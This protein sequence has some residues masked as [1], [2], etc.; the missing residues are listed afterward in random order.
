MNDLEKLELINT[1]EFIGDDADGECCNSVYVENNET[2][3]EII[4]KIGFD[5]DYIDIEMI[6]EDECLNIAVIAFKYCN[7]WNGD[8]FTDEEKD[9]GEFDSYNCDICGTEISSE[10]YEKNNGFCDECAVDSDKWSAICI[11]K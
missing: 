2:N 10:D 6:L 3:R 7:W 8:Y 1:M 5:N 4:N 11:A 9:T